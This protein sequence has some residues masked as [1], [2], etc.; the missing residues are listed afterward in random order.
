MRRFCLLWES[1]FPVSNTLCSILLFRHSS[2][3]SSRAADIHRKGA[4]ITTAPLQP[5]PFLSF[6]LQVLDAVKRDCSKDDEALEY[7][8]EV[9]IDAKER[10]AVSEG[11]EDD[12]AQSGTAYLS[13]ASIE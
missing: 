12:N 9:R 10:Q 4:I 2:Q 5:I 8:L 7:E 11:C 1:G 3:I 6:L 13:N